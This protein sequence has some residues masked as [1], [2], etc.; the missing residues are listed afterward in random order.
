MTYGLGA[1]TCRHHGEGQ[2]AIVRPQDHAKPELSAPISSAR[3][4]SSR[5]PFSSPPPPGSGSRVLVAASHREHGERVLKRN[6]GP[7]GLRA[8]GQRQSR[9]LLPRQM[10]LL[11]F[12]PFCSEGR[13]RVHARE[14]LDQRFSRLDFVAL[15]ANSSCEKGQAAEIARQWA[16][17]LHAREWHDF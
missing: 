14:K 2:N 16:D 9:P 10:R 3:T 17:Q 12:K 7:V 1:R 4:R 15:R 6:G 8:H 11:C 13:C 5:R